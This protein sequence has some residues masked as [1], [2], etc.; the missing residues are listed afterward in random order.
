MCKENATEVQNNT[1]SQ[2]HR[3][4]S[5]PAKKDKMNFG[6]SNIYTSAVHFMSLETQ[7]SQN[8]GIVSNAILPL[9]PILTEN[10]FYV[11]K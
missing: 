1:I 3:Y 5:G 7:N 4:I 6:F 2:T 11:Q 9:Q 8:Q 10:D